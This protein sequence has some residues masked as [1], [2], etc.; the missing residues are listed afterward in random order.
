MLRL[1]GVRA[2]LCQASG[3]HVSCPCQHR[4]LSPLGHAWHLPKEAILLLFQLPATTPIKALFC[5]SWQQG[6]RQQSVG[7]QLSAPSSGSSPQAQQSAHPCLPVPGDAA[8][9]GCPYSHE[10][11][12]VFLTKHP[13]GKGRIW[14]EGQGQP[15]CCS[16]HKHSL[17]GHIGPC[18][19]RSPQ[20]PQGASLSSI[21]RKVVTC[22]TI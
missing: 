5:L 17:R 9:P 3:C 11:N 1:L 14:P 4:G 18:T 7:T 12:P 8:P 6:L 22:N 10:H 16:L 2:H 19:R 15:P 20:P 21:P 13:R